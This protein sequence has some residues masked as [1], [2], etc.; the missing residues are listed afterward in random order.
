[1]Q[2][3]GGVVERLRREWSLL[4]SRRLVSRLIK[5]RVAVGGD[6]AGVFWIKEGR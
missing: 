2:M 1:M 3:I 4:L 6:R 5:V